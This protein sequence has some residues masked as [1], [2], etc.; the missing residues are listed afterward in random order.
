MSTHLFE[1]IFFDLSKYWA[2][3]IALN[4]HLYLLIFQTSQI[5]AQVG[6]VC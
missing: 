2:W 4:I 6:Y 1:Q 3:P 5:K